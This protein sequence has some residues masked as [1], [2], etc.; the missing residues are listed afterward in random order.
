MGTDSHGLVEQDLAFG[1]THVGGGHSAE[2]QLHNIAGY[3]SGSGHGSPR[4]MTAASGQ[5]LYSR[6]KTSVIGLC[7]GLATLT[8]MLPSAESV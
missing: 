2:R 7:S 5:L 1:Q 4:I 8:I 3:E 6:W